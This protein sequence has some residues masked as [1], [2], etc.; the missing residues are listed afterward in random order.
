MKLVDHLD[1]LRAFKIVAESGTVRDAA[2]RLHVTQPALTRT[3]Q[4]LENAV[5]CA[6]FSRSR[7][8]M[9]LTHAGILLAKFANTTLR[10]L[11]DFEAR[12][13][14][15]DNEEAGVLRIGSYESLAEYLWPEF[16]I[17][18]RKI[19]PHLKLLIK[20][21][22]S[23]IHSEALK[24][25]DLDIVV[26]AE[27]RLHGDFTSWHLYEDHFQFYMR[28]ES[29]I[30]NLKPEEIGELPLLYCPSAFDGSN[31]SL[32]LHIEERGFLF[33]E[34]MEFDSFTVVKTFC[35][36]GVGL[37]VLPK[38]LAESSLQK[39]T[40]QSMSLSGFSRSGFGAHK[41]C[42]TVCA[43]RTDDPRILLLLKNLRMYFKG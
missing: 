43:N 15:P 2:L 19:A 16:V 41:L 31:K 25:G 8:G 34:K 20:T 38:R 26:D 28:P 5:G 11:S 35:E 17:K 14:N 13:K 18:F 9:E 23:E 27:P 3:I 12:L 32:L 42:A 21:S 37:A 30:S 36:K 6:L 1:K 4:T 7:S 39:K 33:P 29:G 22:A 40:L 10:N 24:N